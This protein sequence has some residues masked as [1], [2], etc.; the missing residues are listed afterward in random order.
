MKNMTRQNRAGPNWDA[1]APRQ[2][3]ELLTWLVPS[4]THD[5]ISWP[6][7]I[8]NWKRDRVRPRMAVGVISD[9]KVCVFACM[10][11]IAAPM[12][13]LATTQVFH[14]VENSS[15]NVPVMVSL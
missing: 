10:D 5:A 1:T 3:H 9:T 7:I 13:N 4:R 14:S 2:D 6:T 11:P 8:Q 15:T 12:K